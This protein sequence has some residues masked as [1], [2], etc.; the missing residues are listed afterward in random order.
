MHHRPIGVVL[1]IA[2]ASTGCFLSPIP[3]MRTPADRARELDVRCRTFSDQASA[4]ALTPAGV[5]AVEAD[6]AHVPTG[7]ASEQRLQGAKLH[8]RP[9]AGA[10]AQA[11]QRTLECHERAAV[12]GVAPSAPDD[13]FVLPGRWLDL[14]VG[15]EAD[16]FVAVVRADN[17]GDAKQV[18]A[19]AKHYV[20]FSK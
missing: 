19:R 16:G 17:L 12:L 11:L 1:G 15:T 9:L 2:L 8:L 10:T 7:N 18:L 4:P 20:A 13:P 6:Y 5:D 14:D 3:D